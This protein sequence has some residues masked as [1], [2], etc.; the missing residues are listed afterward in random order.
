MQFDVLQCQRQPWSQFVQ[1]PRV[2]S[3]QLAKDVLAFASHSQ[4]RTALVALVHCS[5]QKPFVLRSIDK[6]HRAVVPQ[7]KSFSRICNCDY[8]AFR[9]ACYLQQ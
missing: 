2:I 4:N 9:R 1:L 7:S 8:C 6:L 5:C 3:R